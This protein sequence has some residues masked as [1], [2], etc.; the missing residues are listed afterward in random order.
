MTWSRGMSRMSGILI[1]SYRLKKVTNS[2]VLHCFW[3]SKNVHISA[4]KCLIEME[5]GSKCN[6]LNGQVIYVKNSKLN[7]ADMWLIPFDRVTYLRKMWW[8]QM[9]ER[10]LEQTNWYFSWKEY[11]I[12]LL[13]LVISKVTKIGKMMFFGDIYLYY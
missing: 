12:H 2:Y 13:F 1:L 8:I 7:I 4:T 3:T 10:M 9:Y 5:F 11:T 6:I